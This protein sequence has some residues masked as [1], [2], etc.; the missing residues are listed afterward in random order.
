L[1]ISKKY[2]ISTLFDFL[3]F[4]LFGSIYTAPKIRA[5]WEI[6]NPFPPFCPTKL[7]YHSPKEINKLKF[8]FKKRLWGGRKG[9]RR[10]GSKH[11]PYASA[12]SILRKI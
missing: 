12:Y 2:L 7:G 1:K 11:I 9:L 10:V 4:S 5:V 6:P 3:K 8:K